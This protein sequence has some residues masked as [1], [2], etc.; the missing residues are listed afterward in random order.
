M[1]GTWFAKWLPKCWFC[2]T[3]RVPLF[4]A[5]QVHI[6][7]NDGIEKVKICPKCIVHLYRG[8]GIQ[9]VKKSV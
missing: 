5:H 4:C 8:N 6:K 9:H 2:K 3:E 7:H 1:I